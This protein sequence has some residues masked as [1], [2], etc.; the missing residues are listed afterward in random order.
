[1]FEQLFEIMSFLIELWPLGYQEVLMFFFN[2]I[3]RCKGPSLLFSSM[4]YLGIALANCKFLNYDYF[5]LYAGAKDCVKTT[6]PTCQKNVTLALLFAFESFVFAVTQCSLL[7]LQMFKDLAIP[8]EQNWMCPWPDV[9][10]ELIAMY[11]I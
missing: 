1:M 11:M 5:A 9:T 3:P 6:K 2:G 7:T 10:V 4:I 8:G